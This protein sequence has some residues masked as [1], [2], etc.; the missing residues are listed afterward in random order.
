MF[1]S[2]G[3]EKGTKG[4]E[5]T[6]ESEEDG[7]GGHSLALRVDSSSVF[8]LFSST[9]KSYERGREPRTS[10]IF[11][12][13][14]EESGQREQEQAKRCKDDPGHTTSGPGEVER[15]EEKTRKSTGVFRERRGG[16][17]AGGL[18]LQAKKLS[19][20]TTDNFGGAQKREGQKK[21][22]GDE[23]RQR[24]REIVCRAILFRV[25]VHLLG[26]VSGR[27]SSP[28]RGC[29]DGH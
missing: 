22:I 23:W 16:E 17:G 3:E 9:R 10:E 13:S 18:S 27:A 8:S 6:S 25:Y 2:G 20:N 7:G 14:N 12:T 15:Q 28:S 26:D 4:T 11:L 21:Q 1:Q 5:A 29:E 19:P 24:E